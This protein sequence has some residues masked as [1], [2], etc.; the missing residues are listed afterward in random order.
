MK[1]LSIILVLFLL[2]AFFSSSFAD[3]AESS[4]TNSFITVK[5]YGGYNFWVLA[6]ALKLGAV[7]NISTGGFSFGGDF[8]FGNRRGIQFGIEAAYLP[9]FSASAGGDSFSINFIPLTA[10]VVFNTS[11]FYTDLGLGMAF[12][13][14][15]TSINS[16]FT[17]F[18]APSPAFIGKVGIGLNFKLSEL[19]SI[20]AGL[21]FY[22]PFGDFGLLGGYSNAFA[23]IILFSQINFRVGVGLTF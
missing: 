22:L 11:V 18:S 17:N 1:K 14:A 19:F 8:L 16:A 10:D 12:I 5:L 13:N 3:S 9:A 2:T 21:A 7:T 4:E 15:S 6:S 23:D 20:D